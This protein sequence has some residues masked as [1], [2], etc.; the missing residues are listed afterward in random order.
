M[1]LPAGSK[2]LTWTVAALILAALALSAPTSPGF[3]AAAAP[4][5]RDED[6]A[7]VSA[8]E[9]TW[10]MTADGAAARRARLS[11]PA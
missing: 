5:V 10:L 4:L 3:A 1:L 11:A 6:E 9:N 2:A 8:P 7:L